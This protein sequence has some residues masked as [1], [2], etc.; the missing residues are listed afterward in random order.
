M[1]EDRGGHDNYLTISW[2]AIRDTAS[3]KKSPI[4]PSLKTLFLS[5]IMASD[6]RTATAGVGSQV[7]LKSWCRMCHHADPPEDA[8]CTQEQDGGLAGNSRLPMATNH[9]AGRVM[10][11]PWNN[12]TSQKS[13]GSAH[14][15]DETGPRNGLAL[16]VWP[17]VAPHTIPLSQEFCC[18]KQ[19]GKITTIR[20]VKKLS[21]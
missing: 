2:R 8:T 5:P 1:P 12:K 4:S 10:L 14:H 6:N 9:P 18:W 7:K 13:R 21:L 15:A 19:V 3:L 11:T 16:A 20:G 17:T